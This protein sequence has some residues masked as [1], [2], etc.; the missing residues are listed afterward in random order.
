M[1]EIPALVQI[2]LTP[3][4]LNTTTNMSRKTIIE[5]IVEDETIEDDSY[6]NFE[7]KAAE[8]LPNFKEEINAIA[9][10][11]NTIT[12]ADA[13]ILSSLKKIESFANNID[14]KVIAFTDGE[15]DCAVLE[16]RVGVFDHIQNLFKNQYRFNSPMCKELIDYVLKTTGAYDVNREAIVSAV[17][18]DVKHNIAMALDSAYYE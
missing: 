13:S 11:I 4:F 17:S 1:G 14:K 2:Q 10:A 5:N 12:I 9:D 3:S 18:E 8:S 6:P 7:E 15:G 16:N